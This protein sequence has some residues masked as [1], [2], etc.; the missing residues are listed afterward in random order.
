MQSGRPGRPFGPDATWP[1]GEASACRPGS[2]PASV[3]GG[4]F[5]AEV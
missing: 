2:V 1:G 5:E 4:P 3:C